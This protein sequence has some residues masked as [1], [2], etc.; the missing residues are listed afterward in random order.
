M[1]GLTRVTVGDL[2]RVAGVGRA[3]AR[4][5]A[6]RNRA[7]TPNA[8][9]RWRRTPQPPIPAQLAAY[10]LPQYGAAAVEQFGI[11]MLDTQEP[12]ASDPDRCD[13]NGRL[14]GGASARGVS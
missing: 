10:L 11:V 7:R 1:H 3:R 13:R 9:A 6:R 8:R 12:L 4:A 2:R 14:H 5:G